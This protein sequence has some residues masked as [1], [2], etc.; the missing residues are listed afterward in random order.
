M[1]YKPW[2]RLRACCL[3][4]GCIADGHT[5]LAHQG[6]PVEHCV[7]GQDQNKGG[8]MACITGDAQVL[9]GLVECWQQ[10]AVGAQQMHQPL[11]ACCLFGPGLRLRS[12]TLTF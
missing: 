9:D 5:A 4:S 1:A 6:G 12:I 3:V 2:Q 11:H 7:C 10:A 8:V